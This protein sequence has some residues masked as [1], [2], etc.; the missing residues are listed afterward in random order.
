MKLNLFLALSIFW[1]IQFIIAEERELDDRTKRQASFNGLIDK[2]TINQISIGGGFFK[3]G[4]R[5]VARQFVN[6]FFGPIANNVQN[7]ATSAQA[8]AAVLNS[9]TNFFNNSPGAPQAPKQVAPTRSQSLNKSNSNQ[10]GRVQS[11]PNVL[12]QQPMSQVIRN[13]QSPQ[14]R[15]KKETSP[16]HNQF[17]NVNNS[18][19]SQLN[20]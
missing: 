18:S 7:N 19:S 20:R 12:T 4:K 1:F 16:F 5:R 3:T 8:A 14:A 9:I 13:K 10:N 17:S 11:N 15:Q 6:Q 2:N